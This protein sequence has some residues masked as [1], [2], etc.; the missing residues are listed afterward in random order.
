MAPAFLLLL[1]DRRTLKRAFPKLGL[2]AEDGSALV[3]HLVQFALAGL[4][5]VAD[6]AGQD[7]GR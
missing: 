7:G 5:A 2:T 3:R 6:E 1:F 4:S